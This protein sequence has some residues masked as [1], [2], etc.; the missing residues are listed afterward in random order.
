M[1]F[2]AQQIAQV[3]KGQVDGDP[4]IEVN[5]LSK[6]EEG[7]PGTLS[8]LANPK[9]TSYIYTT[10][11][12][13]VIVNDDFKPEHPVSATLIRVK[14]AYSS[15]A[16]LLE[17]YH[18]TKEKRRGISRNASIPDSATIGKNVFI[19]DFVSIGEN[20]VI[21]DESI[22]H[23]N[24]T[25][26]YNCKVGKSTIIYS[27]VSIYDDCEVGSECTIHAGS[28]IGADGFGFAPQDDN[29]YRKIPQIGNVIIEDKV[30]VGANTTIDRA[31]VGSTIIRKGV[32]IDNLIQVAHNVTIG[33]N[34]VIAAQTGISG[35]T[36]IGK[37]CMIG[38]QVGIIGH[39]KIAD[40]V[41]IAAQ[42][43]IGKSINEEK[44]VHEGSPAFP[45]RDFQRSYVH[46]RR[47]DSIVKRIN[48]VERLIK[49]RE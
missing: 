43:G 13:I 36:A 31:T 23:P 46:F 12:S 16:T 27:G 5:N 26:G 47:F 34:T 2:S 3:L 11:A 1:K 42:S 44:S 10:K 45:Y 20:S 40:G 17:M 8:F 14:D 33:E 19:G 41:M 28:V 29:N 48:V 25:I 30:E 6:I 37:N 24:T 32:K 39:L 21:E 49:E 9:Y 18:Q 35:S 4:D 15:F 7:K 22:I 38:G